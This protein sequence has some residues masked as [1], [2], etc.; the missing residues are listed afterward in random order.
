MSKDLTS[1]ELKTLI[2]HDSQVYYCRSSRGICVVQTPDAD[3]LAILSGDNV[4]AVSRRARLIACL[5]LLLDACDAD[6]LESIAIIVSEEPDE[7][8][9]RVAWPPPEWSRPT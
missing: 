9:P 2:P 3:V 7:G 8:D 5:P 6:T 4:S 1:D